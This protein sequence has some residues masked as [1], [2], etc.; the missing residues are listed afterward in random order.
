[1]RW[2]TNP[3]EGWHDGFA[4]FPVMLSDGTTVWLETF[5]F[6][7]SASGTVTTILKASE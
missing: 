5:R 6:Y 1:M 4:Y 7:V 3:F 2:R